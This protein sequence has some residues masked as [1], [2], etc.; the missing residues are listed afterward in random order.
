MRHTRPASTPAAMS[1]LNQSRIVHSLHA[2]GISSRA[3]IAR[4][5]NLTAPAVGKLV[6]RL[7]D[8]GIVSETGEMTSG[9][10]GRS[11]GLKLNAKRYQVIGVKFA[12][13]LVQI[14]VFDIGGHLLSMEELPPVAD[15]DVE[16]CVE[17][18]RERIRGLLDEDPSIV[19]IGMAVPGPYLRE[20]GRIAVVTSMQ[21]WRGINFI[22]EF[23]MAFRVPTFIEQDA[24]AG[25]MAESLFDSRIGDSSLAY[26]LV[27]EGVGLG[28]IDQGNPVDGSLGAAT[29][30]GHV[31]I[32]MNGTACECGNRGCLECYCSAVAIHTLMGRANQED[33]FPGLAA[34]THKEACD[35]LF[36][37]ARQ[38]DRTSMA[39]L[40][41]VADYVGYGCVT[42]VNAYNPAQIIIGDLVAQAGQPL[43]DRVKSLVSAR[44]LPQVRD[45]T[46][47][48]LSDLPADATLTGAAAVAANQFLEHPSSLGGMG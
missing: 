8:A 42:I 18:V 1:E 38:G 44:A 39:L 17:E 12:R 15:E 41:Q 48:L 27:G 20:E 13:S 26:Y 4:K 35:L 5:L 14:A 2:D 22:K 24:R 3:D 9:G 36:T 32:D 29:E 25:A 46:E 43:L 30:I 11:I 40:D 45:H 47:I 28:V 6:G 10:H 31:S 33:H 7:I 16:D 21:G 37:M 23:G 34:M 19:A